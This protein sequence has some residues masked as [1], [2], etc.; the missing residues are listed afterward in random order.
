MQPAK[1]KDCFTV[2][3]GQENCGNVHTFPDTPVQN[4]LCDSEECVD[5]VSAVGWSL[6]VVMGGTYGERYTKSIL[7][8]AVADSIVVYTYV[9]RHSGQ[10]SV[11]CT[12]VCRRVWC[13]SDCCWVE[14]V[15][16]HGW[17]TWCFSG[18]CRT[19]CVGRTIKS[20]SLLSF[21]DACELQNF[22]TLMTYCF[23]A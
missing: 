21:E 5:S 17:N 10:S 19:D 1:R 18:N 7:L 4:V 16:G 15:G 20:T 3:S 2:Y 12:L 23:V 11:G 14:P 13:L 22:I 6:W 9:F 8:F